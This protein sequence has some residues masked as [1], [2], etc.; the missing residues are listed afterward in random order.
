[1]Y[2]VITKVNVFQETNIIMLYFEMTML[3]CFRAV[4][5]S[6]LLYLEATLYLNTIRP[7]HFLY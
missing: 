4:D 1:M 2:V 3:I 6:K 5:Y 7:E